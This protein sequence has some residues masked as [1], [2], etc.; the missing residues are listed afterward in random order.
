MKDCMSSE[1]S[2]SFRRI[3]WLALWIVFAGAS[4]L[5]VI[6]G[7][8]V[9]AMVFSALIVGGGMAAGIEWYVQHELRKHAQRSLEVLAEDQRKALEQQYH[10]REFLQRALDA[11]PTALF[12]K[13]ADHRYVMINRAFNDL[14]GRESKEI[15]GRQTSE[16]FPNNLTDFI[17]KTPDQSLGGFPL[18]TE[19]HEESFI[20]GYGQRR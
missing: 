18:Q 3:R 13:N 6:W 14:L 15:L 16:L 17:D 9:Y 10:M 11:L 20:D 8:P 5:P 19:E 2:F 7:F 4:L 12:V 1:T